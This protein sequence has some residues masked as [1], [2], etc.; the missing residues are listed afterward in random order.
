MP[1]QRERLKFTF[2]RKI[3]NSSRLSWPFNNWDKQEFGWKE[4]KNTLIK[5]WEG[6]EGNE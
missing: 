5:I 6:A 3:K 2:R 4:T 1:S